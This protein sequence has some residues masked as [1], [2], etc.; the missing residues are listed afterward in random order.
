MG[1]FAVYECIY[2]IELY[3]IASFWPPS[4]G[5]RS[6]TGLVFVYQMLLDYRIV[7]HNK[8]W[9]M[10]DILADQKHIEKATQSVVLAW[11]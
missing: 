5:S 2:R 7:Q 6:A 8:H 4:L 11:P 3:D 1:R 10:M 9:R